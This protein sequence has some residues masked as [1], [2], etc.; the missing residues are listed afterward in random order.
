MYFP[1]SAARQLSTV[2][3]LPNLPPELVVQLV[4][5]PRKDLFCLL[6]RNG[7]AIWRI[8]VRDI[9]LQWFELQGIQP[10]M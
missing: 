1:T 9:S 4:P 10:S 2:P 8:R 7:I 5:S 3:A 6:T